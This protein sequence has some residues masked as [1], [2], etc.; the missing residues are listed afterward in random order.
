MILWRGRTRQWSP[1]SRL[2]E[3]TGCLRTSGTG[4]RRKRAEGSAG[5]R[6]GESTRGET[7]R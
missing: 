4:G 1:Y 6:K 3:C 7:L 5:N 2:A